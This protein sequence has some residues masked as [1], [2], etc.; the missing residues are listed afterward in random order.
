[1]MAVHARHT[2]NGV[3]CHDVWVQPVV[4]AGVGEHHDR[5]WS[6]RDNKETKHAR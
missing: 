5:H 3:V 1:V 6:S 2:I 4:R